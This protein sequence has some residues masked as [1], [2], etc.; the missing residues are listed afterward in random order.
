MAWFAF[1]GIFAIANF[2]DMSRRHPILFTVAL[3]GLVFVPISGMSAIRKI[4]RSRDGVTRRRSF[5]VR[6]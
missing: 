1:F 5:R 3:M 6:R 4:R 2:E